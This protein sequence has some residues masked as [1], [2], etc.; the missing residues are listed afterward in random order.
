[1]AIFEIVPIS[2]ILIELSELVVFDYG[3]SDTQDGLRC[4]RNGIYILWLTS[5]PCDNNS[6]EQFRAYGPSCCMCQPRR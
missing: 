1:M 3:L 6:G 2:I 5:S 4:L